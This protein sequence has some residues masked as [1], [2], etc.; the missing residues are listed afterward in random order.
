MLDS[1]PLPNVVFSDLVM[2]GPEDGLDL[3][4]RIRD[5]W[6]EIAIL[7][8]TGYS[9]AADRVMGEGFKLIAK[10]YEADVLD[11]AIQEVT[12]AGRRNAGRGIGSVTRG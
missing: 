9:D 7:L 2:P 6:P 11:S 1:H 3:A 10:P 5:R 8:A 4:R 12:A